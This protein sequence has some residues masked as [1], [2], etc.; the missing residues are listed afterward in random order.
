M[1]L[2]SSIAR[3]GAIV[4]LTLLSALPLAGAPPAIQSSAALLMDVETGTV[5]YQKA[6]HDS[7]PMASTTKVMTA[8]LALEHAAL[9]EDVTVGPTVNTVT[10]STVGLKP[11]DVVPMDDLLAALLVAS[12]ND[13]AV[14][15]AEHISSTVEDF[16]DLMNARAEQLG[17]TD[18][19]FVN[20]HGLH[21]PNHYASA[22]D[23]ALI[24]RAA[25]AHD[26]FRQ[27]VGAKVADVALPSAPE[28]L[29][30]LINHNK[31]LWRA[32]FTT[33]VKTG[34][35]NQSGHCLIA[36]GEKDGWLFIAV[37]LDSPDM[38]SEAQSLLQYAFASFDRHIYAR[39]GD[40][41]GRARVRG[42]RRSHVPAV[43][44]R[45]LSCLTGPG[46]AEDSRLEVTLKALKAPVSEGEPVGEAHLVAGGRV[47]ASSPLV[48]GQD[49]PR[50]RLLS[51]GLWVLR[52]IAVLAI[53]RIFLHYGRNR[54]ARKSA[55]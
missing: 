46:V 28:G 32:E 42:G 35:V 29:L 31:L 6:M 37:L 38:Y 23:L 53:L 48:A 39:P 11:G 49:V 55:V 7:R 18:T 47:L 2:A 44:Q 21:D 24:T 52:I 50:S 10:G 45:T 17:A 22:Y 36:S 4:S 51:A 26:R 16:A 41:V 33:G 19:H 14:A 12:A 40:A 9:D 20:P 13:A 25:L 5:L 1:R 43:C 8:L 30:R 15:I 27:L 34:F 54:N 3:A